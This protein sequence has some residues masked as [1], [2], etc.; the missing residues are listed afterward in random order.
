MNH[1]GLLN[2]IIYHSFFL[3]VLAIHLPSLSNWHACEWD[4]AWCILLFEVQTKYPPFLPFDLIYVTT[5]WLS[6]WV[7]SLSSVSIILI[8]FLLR[9][10]VDYVATWLL[11]I[12]TLF[13][14]LGLKERHVYIFYCKLTLSLDSFIEVV[15]PNWVTHIEVSSGLETLLWPKVYHTKSLREV[16]K[17]IEL[18]RVK[19]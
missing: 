7:Q 8:I 3:D 13:F 9:V 1:R 6:R 10:E 5:F 16:H 15:S 18:W 19:E 11:A 4:S 17:K 2:D 12:I 14:K